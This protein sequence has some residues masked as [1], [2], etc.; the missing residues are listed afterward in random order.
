MISCAE[1]AERTESMEL[2]TFHSFTMGHI[3]SAKDKLLRRW[4]PE[5]QNI[6]YQHNKKNQTLQTMKR[7]QLQSF[8][9]STATLMTEQLQDLAMDTIVDYKKIIQNASEH[10]SSVS[11]A[12]LR[13]YT[14]FT[15]I[16]SLRLSFGSYLT[17]TRLSLSPIW[18]TS[19]LI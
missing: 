18:A 16:F 19:I 4:F 8:F 6:F 14:I 2:E 15:I 11:K 7:N 1:F 3:E 10:D 9:N 13:L 17:M 5:V 12:L